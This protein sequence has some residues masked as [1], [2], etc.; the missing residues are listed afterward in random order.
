MRTVAVLAGGLGTRIHDVTRGE[1]PKALIPV[2]G[3]PFIHHKLAEVSRLGAD[4]VV[5]LLGH[6][7]EQI[8]DFINACRWSLEIDVV[9]DGPDLLGTGGSIKAAAGL[10]PERFWVTYGDTLLD[11]DLGAAEMH[12][13]Q[14]GFSGVMTVLHN[15]DRWEPS[16]VRVTNDVVEAYCKRPTPTSAEH[17]DYGYLHLERA[18]VQNVPGTSF[19][20]ADV[21]QPLITDRQLGAFEAHERFHDIG[22]PSALVATERWLQARE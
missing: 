1:M 21:L 17:V 6:Q 11:V 5:L 9:S 18:N 10:L 2:N 13:D 22:T 7:S 15:C 12:A 14:R 20:L 8:A 19:D 3:E 16:N 4:R